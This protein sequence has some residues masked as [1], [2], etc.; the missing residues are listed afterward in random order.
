MNYKW[1]WVLN[2]TRVV[3]ILLIPLL[4]LAMI[5]QDGGNGILG[6]KTIFPAWLIMIAWVILVVF[7]LAEEG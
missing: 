5:F 3:I 4:V 2:M 1:K 7:G 6:L